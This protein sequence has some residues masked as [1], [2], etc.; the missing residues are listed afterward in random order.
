MKSIAVLGAGSWGTS[1]AVHLARVGH[2]VSLWARDHALVE[3]M[4]TRRA[5][6]I[7]LPD[8]SLSPRIVVTHDVAAALDA[9]HLIV[10]ATPSHGARAGLQQAAPARARARGVRT[11]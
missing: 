11:A 6:A 10:S 9:A 8:V 3:D 4:R 5:N 2:D 1:L 7:Y